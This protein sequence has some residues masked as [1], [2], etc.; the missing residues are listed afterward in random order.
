MIAE[1][2]VYLY[3]DREL[4]KELDFLL[5]KE[6]TELVQKIKFRGSE[7][8]IIDSSEFYK[9]EYVYLNEASLFF[10]IFDE[11]LKVVAKSENLK[12]NDIPIPEPNRKKFG[13]ADEV[14]INGKRLRIFYLPIYADGKFQGLVET[15]KFEGTVQLAMGLLRTSLLF[16]MF[17]AFVVAI[18]GGNL[19]ISKLIN[20]LEQVIEK[21]DRITA[22]NLTERIELKGSQHPEEIVK[23]VNALNRLFERLDKSFRQISQ[24]TSDVAHELLTPLTIIKDEIEI[25]LM[26]KRRIKEYIDTLDLIQKQTDRTISIVKSM[27]Y[28]AKADAGIIR[29]N[30]QEVNVTELIREIV[31]TFNSKANRKG[32]NLRF[33]CDRDIVIITDEKLLFEALKN[34]VDN[35][36]EYTNSG[37]KVEIVCERRDGN[38]KI[39]ITDTGIGIDESELPHIFDRFYRGKNAFEI[40][41]SGTG[42]GLALTKSIVEIL[43]GRIEVS[44]QRG[45]GT[46][47]VVYIPGKVNV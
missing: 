6:A 8:I 19:I 28:L 47:F 17:L 11:D 39:S 46:K 5:S 14:T 23:L 35:A 40:N 12:K 29:A 24:F 43:S 31:L 30:A 37:G 32:V 10:R 18:Y 2:I 33:Y 21:A 36:I 15:S 42:L 4:H 20:P 45:K 7:F 16:A 41:P 25:T 9:P 22:D 26:K 27:L 44:S 13:R 3:L 1:G 38:V 34:I